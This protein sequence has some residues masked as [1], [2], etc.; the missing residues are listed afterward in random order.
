MVAV[1]LTLFLFNI[2][3]GDIYKHTDIAII[4]QLK[5]I[6]S[7]TPRKPLSSTFLHIL[8]ATVHMV[9]AQCDKK[10]A[11]KVEDN[12]TLSKLHAICSL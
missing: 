11:E 1:L 6:N 2:K 3:Q 12:Q 7:L 4:V 8:F 5:S 9:T 10:Y